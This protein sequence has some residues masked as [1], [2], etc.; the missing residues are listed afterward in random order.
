VNYILTR[1]E[2]FDEDGALPYSSLEA[3]LENIDDNIIENVFII[4]GAALYNQA[5]GNSFL[6]TIYLT[7]VE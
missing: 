5:L 1:N 4:G 3:C 2:N 7:K 6:D